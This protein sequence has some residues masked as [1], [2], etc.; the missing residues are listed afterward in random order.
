MKFKNPFHNELKFLYKNCIIKIQIR[1]QKDYNPNVPSGPST[2]K[3]VA[4]SKYFSVNQ[5]ALMVCFQLQFSAAGNATVST[6]TR[7]QNV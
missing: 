4:T 5:S 2:Y 6:Y 1:Y 7:E 3:T